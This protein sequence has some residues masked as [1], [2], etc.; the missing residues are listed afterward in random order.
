[1]AWLPMSLWGGM[2]GGTPLAALGAGERRC[3]SANTCALPSW[4]CSYESQAGSPCSSMPDRPPRSPPPRALAVM[5]KYTRNA[6][7]CLIG[8]YVSKIIPALQ[9]R[10]TKFRF[11]PLDPQFVHERLDVVVKA[12]GCVPPLQPPCPCRL[13]RTPRAS[14]VPRSHSSHVALPAACVLGRVRSP[15]DAHCRPHAHVPARAGRRPVG[16]ITSV[17]RWRMQG[18]DGPRRHGRTGGLGRGGHAAV[19]QHLTGEVPVRGACAHVVPPITTKHPPW[20]GFC[21]SPPSRLCDLG[22]SL[23][24]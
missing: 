5:E 10:C 24:P 1:M 23:R 9:S 19:A 11:A 15:P 16:C 3:A 18:E 17:H 2:R 12:E 20:L 8:N 13:A 4:L 22:D 21:T 7:F 14:P 6:R